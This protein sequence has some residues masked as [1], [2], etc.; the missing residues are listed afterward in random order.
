VQTY[1]YRNNRKIIVPLVTRE[2][3]GFRSSDFCWGEVGEL[4]LIY[5]GCDDHLSLDKGCGCK[6][7]FSGRKSHKASTTAV[8]TEVEDAHFLR[9]LNQEQINW[10][11]RAGR[12]FQVGDVIERRDNRIEKRVNVNDV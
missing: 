8:L 11:V 2:T 4:A 6:I 10:V 1:Q 3:Q 7:S 12:R 5:H 9:G